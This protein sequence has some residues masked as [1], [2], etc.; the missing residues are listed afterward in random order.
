MSEEEIA[1]LK[2]QA[3]GNPNLN[4]YGKQVSEKPQEIPWMLI[5]MAVGVFFA[6]MPFALKA[7]RSMTKD[8]SNDDQKPE[9]PPREARRPRARARPEPDVEEYED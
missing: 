8:L 1:F 9:R 5:G 7:Y 6:A 3:K 4:K 2:E